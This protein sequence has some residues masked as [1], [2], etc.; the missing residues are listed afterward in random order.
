MPRNDDSDSDSD[1]EG[2]TMCGTDDTSV[3]Q[4]VT[5]GRSLGVEAS[6]K[7]AYKG[8]GLKWKVGQTIYV[9]FLEGPS[10][11]Q[12]KVASIAK[13]WEDHANIKF[14]FV[15][16]GYSDIRISFNSKKGWFSEIGTLALNKSKNIA[17]MNLA[18]GAGEGAVFV[19]SC[20]LHEF[21]HAL[22]LLHEHQSPAS[23]IRWNEQKLIRD[24]ARVYGWTK[25]QVYS[26]IIRKGNSTNYTR[27]DP[28]SIMIYDI[29]KRWTK[30]GRSVPLITKLSKMDKEF[31][32]KMYPFPEESES[33][34]D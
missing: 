31:I 25:Q 6:G 23:P 7:G 9:K 24:H 26:N 30:D 33:E 10:S 11:Y 12:R 20:I 27:F 32:E 5:G 28:K 21:G 13:T 8:R 18:V 2:M 14:K 1:F 17:T 19:N 16:Q 22:G 34:S 15:T 3:S 4:V 29:D